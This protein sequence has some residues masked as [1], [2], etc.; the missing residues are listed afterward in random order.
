MGCSVARR[1][2]GGPMTDE[3]RRVVVAGNLSLDDTVTPAGSQPLAPGGDA[4]YASVGL[5]AWG[6]TPTLLTL[7]GD[8]YPPEHRRRI[9]AS[10][11]DTSRVR[12]IAG[13]TVHYRVTN[14]ADGSRTYEW[15][16]AEARLAATSPQASDYAAL[17]GATWLHVAAM[18]IENQEVGVRAA[19]AAGVPYSLDPHEEYVRGFEPRL[20]AMVEGSIFLP[21]ELEVRLL[22]P[23]LS[24][25]LPMDLAFAAAQRLDAWRPVLV[26]IKLGSLG[27]VVRWGGRTVHVPAPMVDVV[28]PTGAGDAYCGG[29][30][31]GWLATQDPLV[32][33]ACGTIAAG[34]IIGRFGA[35][36]P[37]D[38]TSVEDRIIRARAILASLPP[39]AGADLPVDERLR[40]L[41]SAARRTG[42]A[43][44]RRPPSNGR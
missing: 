18:P 15:V 38:G 25:L 16:S 34:E 37:D 6:V 14:F 2:D 13:P 41:R 21:S 39:S 8:D 31:A 29:F 40:Q 17:D 23:D 22:F 1:T 27:S 10:G 20:L 19:R 7:V 33:A 4:L 24:E 12:D 35:F 9:A 3:G 30:I 28:D 44:I 5:A 42:G 32:G 43:P 26:A 11:I 36:A